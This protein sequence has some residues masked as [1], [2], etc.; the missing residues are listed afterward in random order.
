M[1][2]PSYGLSLEI[3]GGGAG[4]WD[5]GRLCPLSQQCCQKVVSQRLGFLLFRKREMSLVFSGALHA[6]AV[7]VTGVVT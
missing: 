4:A 6:W 3:E 7:H 1:A 5:P 2:L